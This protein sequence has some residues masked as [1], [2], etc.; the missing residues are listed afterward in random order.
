MAQV[1]SG[2]TGRPGFGGESARLCTT[3]F[4]YHAKPK[5]VRH[6][7]YNPRNAKPGPCITIKVETTA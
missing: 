3:A 5:A 4:R 6:W 1:F 2:G 7:S